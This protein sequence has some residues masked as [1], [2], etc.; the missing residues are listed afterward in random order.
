MNAVYAL[1]MQR[2]IALGVVA[3]VLLLS[4][5]Y[6]AHRFYEQNRPQPVWVPLAI[7]PAMPVEKRDEMAKDLKGKLQDRVTLILVSKDLRL[8]QKWHMASDEAAA[9]EIARRLFVK[10]GEADGPH[11]K[12]PSINIGVTGKSKDKDL[13]TALATRLMDDVWKA[14]G[15]SPPGQKDF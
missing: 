4:G 6:F 11:G 13:S 15:V 2:W 8:A 7:N 12:V 5:G 9:S 10:V 3:I 1:G 14:L